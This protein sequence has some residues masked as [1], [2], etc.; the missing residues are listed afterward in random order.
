GQRREAQC[1][2]LGGGALR[3]RDDRK[4]EGELDGGE[5]LERRLERAHVPAL[6]A[7]RPR[8]GERTRAPGEM[9]LEHE[10]RDAAE[11]IAMEM[12]DQDGVDGVARDGEP[13]EP[14]QR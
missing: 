5:M 1:P 8:Q 3:Q 4:V 9:R 11:M 6:D 10:V 12:G 7:G 13:L 2:E 14:G